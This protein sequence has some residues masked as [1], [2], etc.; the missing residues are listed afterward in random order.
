MADGVQR[1]ALKLGRIL[2]CVS[3]HNLHFIFVKEAGLVSQS[4]VDKSTEAAV[5]SARL[6][7]LLLLM[8]SRLGW[9]RHKTRTG[10]AHSGE[11]RLL[12]LQMRQTG[13][14]PHRAR[15]IL[16]GKVED[17]VRSSDG[18]YPILAVTANAHG[19]A[20]EVVIAENVEHRIAQNNVEHERM[21]F[22][23]VHDTAAA[24]AAGQVARLVRM[25]AEMR[26]LLLVLH[27]ELELLLMMVLL[28]KLAAMLRRERRLMLVLK[29]LLQRVVRREA[30]RH[31]TGT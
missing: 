8:V 2:S 15:S 16:F 11:L 3:A 19:A 30:S 21:A 5:A 20:V 12:L 18:A 7:F 6:L 22:R 14:R 27:L 23:K 9:G 25:M 26:R 10:H 24:A 31:L 1:A 29:Q 13:Q 28:L 17:G 4:P